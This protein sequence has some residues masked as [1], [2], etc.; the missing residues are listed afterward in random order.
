MKIAEYI[1]S[2]VQSFGIPVSEADLLDVMLASG[3]GENADD[4]V[5]EE[6]IPSVAY[7]IYSFIPVLLTRPKSISEGG[8]SMSWDMNGLRAYYSLLCKMYGFEDILS[9][10]DR[11]KVKFM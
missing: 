10:E 8:V 6:N 9:D 3:L 1:K 11:P 7:G 4:E 2:K 5:T